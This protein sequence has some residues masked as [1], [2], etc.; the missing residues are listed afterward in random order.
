MQRNVRLTDDLGKQVREAAKAGGFP[1][2]AAFI[3]EAL[4]NAVAAPAGALA[5][6]E[7]RLSTAFSECRYEIRLVQAQQQATLEHVDRLV[8]AFLTCVP[9]PV[10]PVRAREQAKVRYA[11]F[12]RSMNGNAG[13]E[14]TSD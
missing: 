10:E 14:V 3:R 1:S 11:Q 8:K 13:V 7:D 2:I 9:E 4:R 5:T 6:A 12:C